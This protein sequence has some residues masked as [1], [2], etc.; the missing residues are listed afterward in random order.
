[1]EKIQN[2]DILDKSKGVMIGLN[3]K[4]IK[5]VKY[6]KDGDLVFGCGLDSII[7]MINTNG[8]VVGSFQKEGGAVNAIQPLDFSL[9]SASADTSLN[10][11]DIERGDCIKTIQIESMIKSIDESKG[12]IYFL[13]DNSMNMQGVVGR[14][15]PRTG[16]VEKLYLP[17]IP[18]TKGFVVDDKYIIGNEKGEIISFCLKT[19]KELKKKDEHLSKVTSIN[20]NLSKHFFITS[21]LDCTMKII[22]IETLEVKRKFKSEEPINCASIFPTNDIVISGGGINARDVTITKGKSTFDT[23]FYDIATKQKIGFYNTHIGPVNSAA[24]SPFGTQI[25]TG[26]E[27]G[28]IALVNLGSDFYKAPFTDLSKYI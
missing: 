21:S 8:H 9:F 20:P 4:P 15:D 13:S 16:E 11:W 10:H 14:F 12:S 3:Q 18:N 17:K 25:A 2:R 5:Q 7:T 26:G 6:N 24:V 1:M 19:N 23:S 27:D 22:D 28:R